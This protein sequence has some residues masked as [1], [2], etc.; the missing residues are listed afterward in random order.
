M[1]RPNPENLESLFIALEIAAKKWQQDNN[2]TCIIQDGWNR[3]DEKMG[4]YLKT[5]F[6]EKINGVYW[7]QHF[8]IAK[9]E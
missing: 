7:W 4:S 2:I 9:I 1:D 3:M 6:P 8:E 5:I